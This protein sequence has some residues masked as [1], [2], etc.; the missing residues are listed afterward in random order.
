MVSLAALSLLTITSRHSRHRSV[1]SIIFH[2]S[3][4][5]AR[6]HPAPAH[7]ELKSS[8][9]GTRVAVNDLFG[10]M[11]VRVK[12]RALTLQKQEAIE[13]EWDELRHLL[14][15]VMLANGKLTKL[16]VLDA[17]GRRKL[18]I[19]LSSE[20]PLVLNR[21]SVWD[22][23]H[24][25]R[26]HSI[27]A[28][29]GMID[30]GS[31]GRWNTVSANLPDMS[32]HAAISLVPG[33]TKKAQFISLGSS[34]VFVRNNT[35]AL[36]NEVNRVFTSSAFGTGFFEL[37]IQT[38]RL[39]EDDGQRGEH[40]RWASKGVNKWPMFYIR[41]STNV[42]QRI[43]D[44]DYDVVPESDKSLQRILDVLTAMLNE[45]LKENNLRP[46]ALKRKRKANDISRGTGTEERR[47]RGSWST[48]PSTSGGRT[49]AVFSTEETLDDGVKL[50][51]FRRHARGSPGRDFATWS[52]VKSSREHVL[53][54][55]RFSGAS[56][57]IQQMVDLPHRQSVVVEA[58]DSSY[59][60]V[61]TAA[62]KDKDALE[63]ESSETSTDLMIPWEDP[64]T[65][66]T[67]LI[68]SRTGQTMN[69]RHSVGGR[70]Q[71][72]GSIQTI[73][74]LDEIRRPRSVVPQSQNIWIDNMLQEW[75]N[76][77]FKRSERPVAS[78][79]LEAQREHI[80]GREHHSCSGDIFGM[81]AARFATSRGKLWRQGLKTAEVIAQVD[82]KFILAKMGA[83]GGYGSGT[84]L[85]L[86]DQ[87]AAD[88]R[89]RIEQLFESFFTEF[90]DESKT[91][92]RVQTTEVEEIRFEIGPTE[93][94][95]FGRYLEHLGS[96]GISYSIERRKPGS[97]ALGVVHVRT[98]PTLIAERCRAEPNL[99]VDL[100][101]GEI[102]KREE[103]GEGPCPTLDRT[104]A[105]W[106]ERISG[107]PQ[108][109]VDLLNSRACRSAIMFN[110]VLG[111]E[112]CRGLVSRLARCRFPFQCAH[113]RPSMV[114][115]L[116]MVESDRNGDDD[117]G[118]GDFVGAFR[119][120]TTI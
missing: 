13:K 119:E 33:P 23:T 89:C 31:S 114:P 50:P 68:N 66:R 46:R 111:M 87:H 98:L 82:Q 3:K 37:P 1:N 99:V 91:V 116:D 84:V 118:G 63:V 38:T 47:L 34:P 93:T 92:T 35:N 32:I 61:L 17:E 40:F 55:T 52:R 115:I 102:W 94:V 7:Q 60:N 5:V 29:A 56:K 79:E 2:H 53:D 14:V 108:G 78:T 95:L 76:P 28:Q 54:D 26:I 44:D 25:K 117:G 101:R 107:C 18:T 62:P 71:S 58:R 10:N 120:W 21:D 96:W 106:V 103:S 19:R 12:S 81:E 8:S 67:V 51:S 49:N 24:F 36:Y 110:D 42:P 85:V 109:I 27:L 70:P 100:L 73:R 97:Q 43:S 65:R 16:V 4:P 75:G 30:F 39:T 77:I 72:T 105:S 83:V 86:I 41:I 48:A 74:R 45:F 113:G 15:A 20:L 104:G 22:E 69:P 112:E 88:E 9:H 59:S 80:Y 90:S 6:L 11:P 64:Y 57:R